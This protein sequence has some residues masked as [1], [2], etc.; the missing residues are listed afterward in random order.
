MVFCLPFL[1]HNH[2]FRTCGG[3]EAFISTTDFKKCVGK[4]AQEGR[5]GNGNGNG[6]S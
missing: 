1:T 5:N 4:L 3:P 2:S 6:T